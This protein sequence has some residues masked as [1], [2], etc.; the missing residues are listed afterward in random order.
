M[1]S[2]VVKILG[3]KGM[4]YLLKLT[5]PPVWISDGELFMFEYAI[6]LLCRVIQL[7]IEDEETAKKLALYASLME[8]TTRVVF[9]VAFAKAGMEGEG[10]MM[11]HKEYIAYITRGKLRVADVENDMQV[12]YVSTVAAASVMLSLPKTGAF[13]FPSS[14]VSD[15]TIMAVT[16]YQLTLEFVVD[17][18][19]SFVENYGGLSVLHQQVWSMKTGRLEGAHFY[20]NDLVRG[21]GLKYGL[22]IVFTAIMLIVSLV[23]D[24]DQV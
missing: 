9:Y 10:K 7:L 12:E 13:G 11:T 17:V 15:A 24:G 16:Q 22:V 1:L 18:I 14:N 8:V 20:K 21:M 4:L 2:Q 5:K 19:C 23:D 3:N 6:S